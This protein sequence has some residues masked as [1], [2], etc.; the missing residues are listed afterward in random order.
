MASGGDIEAFLRRL[1]REEV[2]AA[3]DD[4]ERAKPRYVT[5][6]EYSA[7]RSISVSMVRNAIRDERLPSIR[8]GR[9]VRVPAG[10]E[11]TP[12]ARKAVSIAERSERRLGLVRGGRG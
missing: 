10:V 6:A 3:L 2:T 8:S 5:I 7:A 9:S 1:I 12:V 4:L 11:I